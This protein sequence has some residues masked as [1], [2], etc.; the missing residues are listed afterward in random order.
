MLRRQM[1]A[2]MTR[3]LGKIRRAVWQA[4][5]VDDVL[6]LRPVDPFTTNAL[7]VN[8]NPAFE[9]LTTADKVPA[10]QGWLKQLVDTE[11]LSSD[12]PSAPWTDQYIGSAY[13]QGIKRGY[14]DAKPGLR[15]RGQGPDGTGY[16][17]YL[18]ESFGSNED[19]NK[20]KLL[21]TRAFTNLKGVSDAMD[22][23]LS[24]SLVQ[25]LAEGRAP[26]A[27]A[28]QMVDQID[29]LTKG[30]AATIARTEII[31]AHAEGQLDGFDKAGLQE[32]IV[33]AEWA[34]AGDANVCS[35]CAPLQG[36]I[37]TI[38]EARGMIPRHPNCR[39]AWL[40]AAVGEESKGQIWGNRGKPVLDSSKAETGLSDG[41][42]AKDKSRWL[43]AKK[44]IPNSLSAQKPKMSALQEANAHAKAV[45]ET[46]KKVNKAQAAIDAAK[47]D[48]L[49]KKTLANIQAAQSKLAKVGIPTRPGDFAGGKLSDALMGKIFHD[50]LT[51]GLLLAPEEF[52]AATAEAAQLET[53]LQQAG[54][55][56]RKRDAIIEGHKAAA[57]AI[58]RAA[59]AKAVKQAAL[60]ATKALT[61]LTEAEFTAAG[62]L[63]TSG[64]ANLTETLNLTASQAEAIGAATT[65]TDQAAVLAKV[66]PEAKATT[67]QA[68]AEAISKYGAKSD[69]FTS[70]LDAADDWLDMKFAMNVTEF[71]TGADMDAFYAWAGTKA[72]S[73][74]V[75]KN[76][77]KKIKALEGLVDAY[78][79]DLAT[80][81][82]AARAV[83]LDEF[84]KVLA[85]K[86]A[87]V[88][89]YKT[90]KLAIQLDTHPNNGMVYA[91]GYLK[92]GTVKGGPVEM[93][94]L[95]DR[96]LSS[97]AKVEK[98]KLKWGSLN[99]TTQAYQPSDLL[100]A[101][102]NSD[103]DK[104][105]KA[106]KFK[107]KF[108][109]TEGDVAVQAAKWAEIPELKAVQVVD[110]DKWLAG[111]KAKAA[112]NWGLTGAT[113]AKDAALAEVTAASSELAPGI[114]GSK[115]TLKIG[116]VV[117]DQGYTDAI[118][119]ANADG[120]TA[121]P[122]TIDVADIHMYSEM[123]PTEAAI[124][125]IDKAEGILTQNPYAN[126]WPDVSV[127]KYN[128]KYYV[129]SGTGPLNGAN[130]AGVQKVTVALTD[131]D[132]AYGTAAKAV[133]QAP[134]TPAVALPEFSSIKVIKN[135]PGSTAPQLVEDTTT[136]LQW[137]MK[138]GLDP[139]HVRSEALADELYRRAGF[140][141][142]QSGIVDTSGGPVKFAQYLDG[143]KTLQ[144]WLQ[145]APAADATAMMAQ[146]KRGF[147]MDALLA[148][149][150]VAGLSMDNIFVVGKTAYR[151]DNGGAL[152]YRA[153]GAAKR[154]FGPVVKELASMR[155][156]ATNSVT[157]ELYAGITDGEIHDQI[158]DIVRNRDSI[159]GAIADTDLRKTM[160]ERI[161]WL[162][163]QLPAQTAAT[164]RAVFLQATK[165]PAVYDIDPAAIKRIQAARINGV[166]VSGDSDL[167]EDNN[168]L[169]W[170]ETNAK[171]QAVTRVQ[172][173]VTAKGSQTLTDAL[174]STSKAVKATATLNT[175]PADVYWTAFENAAKTVSTHAKDGNYNAGT[176]AAF[177]NAKATLEASLKGPADPE[178]KAMLDFYK[179]MAEDI[180]F[181]K[182]AKVPTDKR[183]QYEVPKAAAAVVPK[184]AYKVTTGDLSERVNTVQRGHARVSGS[185]Q[186]FSFRSPGADT[187]FNISADNGVSM[188]FVPS[189][190]T[191]G[192]N[193][194]G[195]RVV[196]TIE[197]PV[198]QEAID[199]LKSTMGSLGV[200]LAAPTPAQ[201]EAL[202]IH[203]TINLRGLSETP[204]Y[205][206][207]W[208]D[209]SI[210]PDEKVRKLKDWVKDNMGIQL[211]DKPTAAY[212]PAGRASDKYGNGFRIWDRWDQPQ[213]EA[214][215]VLAGHRL[216]HT[217]GSLYNSPP[218][219]VADLIPSLLDN[220]GELTSTMSR[221]R[222]GIQIHNVGSA[223][224]DM[225]T[226]GAD[227]IFTRLQTKAY[228]QK[229][230]GL[231]FKPEVAARVD[232][233]HYGG[234]RFGNMKYLNERARTLEES[235][236]FSRSSSN[237]MIFKQGLS[238]ID[239]IL[240]IR[241][242]TTNE[243]QRVIDAY[244]AAGFEVLPDGRKVANIVKVIP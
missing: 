71:K 51:G 233:V 26:G 94:A 210:T 98:K 38:A 32:V 22:Q 138:S 175:H 99:T 18:D 46:A 83:Q 222:K 76:P 74:D 61:G 140:A 5:G 7:T 79:L 39:C 6:G 205:K 106:I 146:V 185:K 3:R 73:I 196:A 84:A 161:G 115:S 204:T 172:F 156:R 23:Q 122:T 125:A 154:D 243:R 231:M 190:G 228:S 203:K 143:G 103:W 15:T 241:V 11:L 160:G 214:G 77:A 19:V 52:L 121:V 220:G 225:A 104:P 199:K 8:D 127:S 177:D 158:R 70:P 2:D 100:N 206:T 119:K 157:A 223:E 96:A 33:M 78:K 213:S 134:A 193:A 244:K 174:P 95:A 64:L 72:D 124:K 109:V 147:V 59:Q 221:V 151:I 89:D 13:K 232:A 58:A 75:I 184:D 53:P 155:D 92:G 141:V 102:K 165:T 45:A 188:N 135:L 63:D 238:I 88:P 107:G 208:A 10:F 111:K 24:N 192:G 35:K 197:G 168:L 176:L 29:G 194:F 178:K 167:I 21:G 116:K 237:E 131:L 150:D 93:Q 209:S 47:A 25:G 200:D 230:S 164:D 216:T 128:G 229:I 120:L 239:D 187:S 50:P 31:H 149:H 144:Q 218:G 183:S 68:V 171:G 30:R 117:G 137:V 20:L 207:I 162:E 235:K 226:G 60:D 4:I 166:T 112:G 40:P 186:S 133:A 48:R 152:L 66:V 234:D 148:N 85:A 163:A 54:Y 1:I 181:A 62:V 189:V 126:P 114:Q 69:L 227:F 34:T 36:V 17:T 44:K 169:V 57:K 108:I 191:T 37:F 129:T 170:Q 173:K 87:K 86:G 41:K 82:Q 201:E 14:F 219:A 56:L 91:K 123:Y 12:N 202:Y 242:H 215:K 65:A 80:K 145:T 198:S 195:G 113:K 224:A 139:G 16:T 240:E 212:N 118:V 110:I 153:Q 182:S 55:L 211:P 105:V 142:P 27:I 136:G 101:A 42:A 179:K 217:T 9:F 90:L 28:K 81:A 159:L 97:G 236:G 132:A 43:G 67:Q 130:A 49:K 180:E